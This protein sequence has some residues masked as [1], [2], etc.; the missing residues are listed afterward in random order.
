MTLGIV[1]E[2]NRL[3]IEINPHLTAQVR[4]FK[5]LLYVFFIILV[6]VSIFVIKNF[7]YNNS[8][9]IIF[10]LFLLVFCIYDKKIILEKNILDDTYSINMPDYDFIF[11]SKK[12]TVGPLL[13]IRAKRPFYKSIFITPFSDKY[14]L[15]LIF[16]KNAVN[17]SRWIYFVFF[18]EKSEVEKIADLLGVKATFED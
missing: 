1:Q 17:L 13:E 15:S 14:V 12:V 6:L 9:V 10:F 7:D 3:L 18:L 11:Q 5:K 2:N 8:L 16:K 4:V